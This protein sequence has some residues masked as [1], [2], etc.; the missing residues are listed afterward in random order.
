MM[1]S[2]NYIFLTLHSC[3]RMLFTFEALS[4]SLSDL[5]AIPDIKTLFSSV[6][7]VIAKSRIPILISSGVSIVL[8]C[9]FLYVG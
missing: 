9:L 3:L 7:Q 2:I 8:I 5:G 1:L 6:F 4:L